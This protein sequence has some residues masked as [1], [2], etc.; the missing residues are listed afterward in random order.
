MDSNTSVS[1]NS[2]TVSSTVT[3]TVWNLI[4]TPLNTFDKTVLQSLI[5]HTVD[6]INGKISQ[7]SLSN[8]D[9]H[10]VM[11]D[12][13]YDM[14]RP[15]LVTNNLVKKITEVKS[16]KKKKKKEKKLKKA[17]QIRMN[18]TVSKIT[19]IV[20]ETILSYSMEYLKPQTGF[21]SEYIEMIAVTFIYMIRFMIL[22][23]SVYTKDYGKILRTK[24]CI[25][26]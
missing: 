5:A 14:I 12:R 8:T 21:R 10:I 25:G 7:T 15:M 17:D 20:S 19:S 13:F 23:R 9:R 18:N 4:E 16:S 24:S 1:N 3:K 6:T 11:T 26:C 22:H 2:K